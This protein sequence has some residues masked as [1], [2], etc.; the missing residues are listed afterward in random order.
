[1]YLEIKN[2]IYREHRCI[3]KQLS[4]L[5]LKEL[6]A[7]VYNSDLGFIMRNCTRHQPG[8]AWNIFSGHGSS[9]TEK[10]FYQCLCSFFCPSS[11]KIITK[12]FRK[13]LSLVIR[14]CSKAPIVACQAPIFPEGGGRRNT[15]TRGERA[16]RSDHVT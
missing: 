7:A 11:A 13:T 16:G 14:I 3:Q 12:F 4:R 6:I 15:G 8:V 1:M 10:R 5:A 9:M 2:K